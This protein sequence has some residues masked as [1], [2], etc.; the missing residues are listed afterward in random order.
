MTS[1]SPLTSREPID[2][3]IELMKRLRSPDGGCPWDLEQDFTTIAPYTIEEAYEVVDAI[4]RGDMDDLKEELGDLLLQVIFHSQMAN[5]AGHFSID[6]VAGVIVDKMVRRHPH[7]FLDEGN[8]SSKEQRIAWEEIK[9]SERERKTVTATKTSALEGVALALPALIRAEKL[10]K[11]AARVGF[12][13]TQTEQIFAKLDEEIEEVQE[14]ISCKS[15]EDIEDELGDLM[16]VCANLARN[17][18]VDPEIALRK[19]NKKFERR[20]RAM[21][22]LAS[23]K[24]LNFSELNLETQEALWKE[25]KSSELK[26]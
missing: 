21:E 1:P 24:G 5:E 8:R 10:Q 11:R 6:D 23:A 19:A 18:K 16:F 20:F 4:E 12:D 9:A 15:H 25:V 13:W 2:R 17:L 22:S 3:L 7:V 26:T 14:A